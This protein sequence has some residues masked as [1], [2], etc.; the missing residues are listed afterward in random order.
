[1]GMPR[2]MRPCRLSSAEDPSGS[3]FQIIWRSPV[4]LP[5]GK[6]APGREIAA[7]DAIRTNNRINAR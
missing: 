1:M 4:A 2:V 7:A 6:D 5:C 3:F